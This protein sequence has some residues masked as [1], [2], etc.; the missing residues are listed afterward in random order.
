MLHLKIGA[1]IM[2]IYNIDTCDS[3]TNGAMG[4]L[5]GYES[6]FSYSFSR[7]QFTLK[8][9]FSATS[10]KFQG[11][12]VIKPNCLVVDFRS[13]REPAQGYV[14]LSRIQVLNQL[15]IVEELPVNKLKP[16][17]VALKE[18]E[19]LENKSK[20]KSLPQWFEIAL[21]D[22]IYGSQSERQKHP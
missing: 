2:L 20:N 19:R 5:I 9:A 3:L 21:M 7:K 16:S 6:E 13:L 1:R 15:F 14:M 18:V 11:Q 22:C 17:D 4:E 8:I 12:T 10:H